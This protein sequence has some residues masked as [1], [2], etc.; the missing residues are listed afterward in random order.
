MKQ[1]FIVLILIAI[2][3]PYFLFA[4]EPAGPVVRAGE[5]I[6]IDGTQVVDGDLYVAGSN[7]SISGKS[8]QDAFVVGMEVT[9]NNSTEHDLTLISGTAQIHGDVGDD[10]RVLGGS[11]VIASHVKGDVVVMGGS[12]DILSTASIDGDVLFW[13]TNMTIEAPIKGNIHGNAENVRING[14]VEGGVDF[15]A[16]QSLV[17]GDKADIQGD[18]SYRS[19]SEITRAQGAVVSGVVQKV[20]EVDVVTQS[21]YNSDILFFIMV[22][23]AAFIVY[24]LAPSIV[25]RFV[26]DTDDHLGM[27]GLIGLGVLIATPFISVLLMISIVGFIAGIALLIAYVSLVSISGILGVIGLG[28]FIQVLLFKNKEVWFLTPILGVVTCALLSFVPVIGGLTLLGIV[29]ISL[30]ILVQRGYRMARS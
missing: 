7:V 25:Q 29:S 15:T 4:A 8:N 9:I 19:G 16:S 13:G 27:H 21:H 18:V 14:L 12:L 28:K 1:A 30:G 20:G 22:L 11:V 2:T 24:V 17:L 26:R 10:L 23:F 5:T 6:S 3:T